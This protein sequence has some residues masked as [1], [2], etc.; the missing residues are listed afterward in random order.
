MPDVSLSHQSPILRTQ[1]SRTL[2]YPM[3]KN[4]TQH[5]ASTLVSHSLLTTASLTKTNK[6]KCLSRFPSPAA[7]VLGSWA[8]Q[9]LLLRF[10]FNFN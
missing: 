10:H 7:P 6:D 3:P 9:S 5:S 1:S 4:G 2:D 8:T